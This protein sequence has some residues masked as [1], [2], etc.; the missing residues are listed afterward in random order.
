MWPM[1][2]LGLIV[3]LG[4]CIIFGGCAVGH[5]TWK[6]CVCEQERNVAWIKG[7]VQ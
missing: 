7:K 4:E 3:I 6:W 2:N 5:A 1:T